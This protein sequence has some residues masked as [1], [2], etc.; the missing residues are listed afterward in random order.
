MAVVRARR[1]GTA[2]SA[3]RP[4]SHPLLYFHAVREDGGVTLSACKVRIG[5]VMVRGLGTHGSVIF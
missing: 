5:F 3:G 1:Y 2:E 4:A